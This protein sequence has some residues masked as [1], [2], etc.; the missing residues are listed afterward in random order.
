MKR[1]IYNVISSVT[2]QVITVS[3]ICVSFMF[4]FVL[5]DAGYRLGAVILLY[6]G[7]AFFLLSIG[8]LL[9]QDRLFEQLR[10]EVRNEDCN[11]D[12]GQPTLTQ[13]GRPV[14]GS[15]PDK[16]GLMGIARAVRDAL[17]GREIEFGH[18]ADLFLKQFGIRRLTELRDSYKSDHKN[19]TDLDM[20]IERA[21]RTGCVNDTGLQDFVIEKNG[22]QLF[23]F[24]QYGI[25][26]V[27][28][29][30]LFPCDS[31]PRSIA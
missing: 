24:I 16:D 29:F 9:L 2:Y 6:A 28:N 10:N 27:G 19:E 22:M 25:W 20:A 13:Q 1:I 15:C 14:P 18:Q 8:S 30:V 12:C 23:V 4:T 7:V 11:E 26:S 5:A 17:S 21:G 31:F 3:A